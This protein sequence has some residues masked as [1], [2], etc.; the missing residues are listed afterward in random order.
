MNN[1]KNSK[2]FVLGTFRAEKENSIN[3]IFSIPFMKKVF[4]YLKNIETSNKNVNLSFC[5]TIN[6]TI[7]NDSLKL[8]S[9]K[10]IIIGQIIPGCYTM[11]TDNI[12]F[13]ALIDTYYENILND[14]KTLI[15]P[16]CHI[17]PLTFSHKNKSTYYDIKENTK[18]RLLEMVVFTPYQIPSKDSDKVYTNN[19]V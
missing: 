6:L 7:C 13:D 17:E 3:M 9:N 4:E 12:L 18:L 16:L 10:K 19:L 2:R 11:R 1:I 15:I 5:H 8:D 14:P